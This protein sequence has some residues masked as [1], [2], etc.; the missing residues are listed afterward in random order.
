MIKKC[1]EIKKTGK[2]R[3]EKTSRYIIKEKRTTVVKGGENAL[4]LK[5]KENYRMQ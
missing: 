1:W 5:K 2:G 3:Y 4:N